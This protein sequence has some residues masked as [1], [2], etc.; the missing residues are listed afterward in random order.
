MENIFLKKS[1]GLTIFIF[2]FLSVFDP[3]ESFVKYKIILLIIAVLITAISLLI[4][5]PNIDIEDFSYTILFIFIPIITVCIYYLFNL[6]FPKNALLYLKSYFIIILI[7]STLYFKQDLFP[8]I[9]KILSLLSITIILIYLTVILYPQSYSE[10]RQ[11]LEFHGLANLDNRIYQDYLKILSIGFV[12]APMILF[13]I[14]YYYYK[15]VRSKKIINRIFFFLI[16]FA[17]CLALIMTGIRTSMLSVFILIFMLFLVDGKNRIFKLLFILAITS[18]LY[19]F[20][21]DYL[22]NLILSF[23]NP[24]EESNAIKIASLYDYIIIF[25]DPYY[26]LFGQGLGAE[27]YWPSRSELTPYY[28]SITELTYFEIFR[29][30]GL[31]IGFLIIILLSYPLIKVF[32]DNNLRQHVYIKYISCGY[33]IYLI[34]CFTNPNLFNSMG[35]TILVVYYT[36][37]KL[38]QKKISN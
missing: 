18:S 16:I 17:N 32:N 31:F 24:K 8:I 25:S 37:I 1:F 7:I 33:L 20:F 19:L 34:S 12:T 22:N 11:W 30:Y 5:N 27:T 15:L 26:V 3:I 14:P 9:A 6:N 4:F 13:V 10:I 2:L 29:W 35:I 28:S 21:Y 23:F 38:L 36:S